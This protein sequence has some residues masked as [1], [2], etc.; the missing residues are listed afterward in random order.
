MINLKELISHEYETE[1]YK[2]GEPPTIEDIQIAETLLNI[3]FPENF[4]EFVSQVGWLELDNSYFF[5]IPRRLTDE[6]NVVRMTQFARIEWGLPEN[7]IVV[8]L[9]EDEVLWCM[10]E[11]NN[12]V[13]AYDVNERNFVGIVANSFEEALVDYIEG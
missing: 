7:Y 12:K 6:G 10:E 5:G 11:N 3:N 4:R 2:F 9:S 13:F 1:D 8:Y